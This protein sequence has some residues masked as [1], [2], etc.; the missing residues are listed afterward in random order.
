MIK[1]N[2][3]KSFDLTEYRKAKLLVGEITSI[4]RGFKATS[5]YFSKHTNFVAVQE[6]MQIINTNRP[7]LY[8]SLKKYKTILDK[9]GEI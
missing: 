2:L 8:Q 5:L 3:A 7:I 9:K 4:L 1:N 6:L